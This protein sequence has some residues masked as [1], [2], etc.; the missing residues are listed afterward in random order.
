MGRSTFSTATM[1]TA[2]IARAVFECGSALGVGGHLVKGGRGFQMLLLPGIGNGLRS[3]NKGKRVRGGFPC[4]AL[5]SWATVHPIGARRRG[6]DMARN[7]LLVQRFTLLTTVTL[8]LLHASA[9]GR[10]S[11]P[12][13]TP[14]GKP[15]LTG[16]YSFSTVT[17]LQRPEAL[18]GKATLTDEEAAAFEASENTR[19]NRDLFDPEKGQPSAGYPPRS[20]GGVLSYNEFWYER[21]NKLTRDRRT[22][23]IVDPPDGRIPFTD[24]A[25]RR[26]ADMRQRSDSGLGDSYADRPLAD[27][28]LQ[29]F[30]SG[31]PMTPGAYNNNVEI[32][33]SLGVVVIVNEM[34]H[35]ARVIP[36]DGR[37]H[38]TL[39]QW[40]GD[41][42]GRWDGDTLVV[43]TI[44]FRR[45][46]SLQ[47]STASTRL[48]ERFTR[49]D[50]Q[51]IKYEF[52]VTDPAAYTRP[53]TAMMPL[54]RVREPIFEYACHEGNYSLRNIL[55]GAR[56]QERQREK[57]EPIR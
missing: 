13:R 5:T 29:G 34:V 57:G 52:T 54:T 20:Q 23:L 6:G 3:P 37:P 31:P 45:E 27:R 56:E 36:T 30:N 40:S 22:S 43:E 15:D 8:A 11:T 12:A 32:V 44:N 10:G 49:V 42:R 18:A 47:G 4:T 53:W 28:C 35:N 7:H 17:P 2:W 55:A 1:A 16:I 39:R 46:T 51:T 41:S 26:V 9:Q 19:L 38:T 24:A 25:R 14:D 33:Q 50:A 48:V 21:G